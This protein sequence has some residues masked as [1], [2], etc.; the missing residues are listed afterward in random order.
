MA[1]STPEECIQ[2]MAAV[3]RTVSLANLHMCFPPRRYWRQDG[4]LPQFASAYVEEYLGNVIGNCI[5]A[6]QSNERKLI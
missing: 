5:F 1:Q 6:H 3:C 2:V 4:S